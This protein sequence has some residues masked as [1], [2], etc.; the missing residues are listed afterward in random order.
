[1]D[2]F[3]GTETLGEGPLFCRSFNSE[4]L[5][6]LSPGDQDRFSDFGQGPMLDS[7]FDSIHSAIETQALCH[8]DTLA[9]DDGLGGLTY[10]DLDSKAET[11]ARHLRALGLGAGDRIGLFLESSV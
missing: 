1:M 7:P 4:A 3:D 11:L 8:P 5:Q 6:G 10:L 9:V 2:Y